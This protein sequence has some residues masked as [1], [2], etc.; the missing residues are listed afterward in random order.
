MLPSYQ[1]T[2]SIPP[3]KLKSKTKEGTE[4]FRDNM[5]RQISTRERHPNYPIVEPTLD[6]EHYVQN[7]RYELKRYTRRTL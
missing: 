5:S 7:Y 1:S 2:S 4:N 6:L 3:Q